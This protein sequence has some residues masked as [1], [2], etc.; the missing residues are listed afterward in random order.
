MN[1]EFMRDDVDDMDL[2]TLH[3]AMDLVSAQICKLEDEL[4]E[5]AYDERRLIK[6][7]KLIQL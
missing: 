7:L 2:T 3:S 4:G 5:D 6:L 1:T